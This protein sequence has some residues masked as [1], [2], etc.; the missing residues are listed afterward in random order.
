ME[1]RILRA[2]A[3]LVSKK[4]SLSQNNCDFNCSATC[5]PKAIEVSTSCTESYP[6]SQLCQVACT[7]CGSFG[8]EMTIAKF[9]SCDALA[10]TALCATGGRA[11]EPYNNWKNQTLVLKDM[12]PNGL[13]VVAQGVIYTA[14]TATTNA[15]YIATASSSTVTAATVTTS[16]LYSGAK[17]QSAGIFALILAVLL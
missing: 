10:G 11:P 15:G 9:L 5:I 14:T 1:I 8:V 16:N 4:G 17:T 2:A 13:P 3:R 12:N 6:A 7:K